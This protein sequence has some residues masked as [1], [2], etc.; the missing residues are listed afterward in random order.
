M[1]YAAYESKVVVQ[2]LDDY[3]YRSREEWTTVC[4]LIE[5]GTESQGIRPMSFSYV[6]Y[7]LYIYIMLNK[8]KI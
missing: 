2:G 6:C 1:V 3:I 8:G 4:L 7:E 5:R